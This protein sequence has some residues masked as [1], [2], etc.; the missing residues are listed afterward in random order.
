MINFLKNKTFKSGFA[1]GIIFFL[2]AQ[3]ISFLFYVVSTTW[4]MLKTPAHISVHR[5]WDIG[6]PFSMYYGM[7]DFAHGD[8]DFKGLLGNLLF[9]LIFS[10]TVG[11]VFKFVL[12]KLTAKELK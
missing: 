1:L 6:F 5:F 9:A 10:L 12:G 2:L 11:L 7:Y 8:F 3:V 4:L